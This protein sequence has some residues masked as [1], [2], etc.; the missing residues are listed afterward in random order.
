[1][2]VLNGVLLA[3]MLGP[4]E[5]GV[6][7]IAIAAATLLGTLAA[8][9]LP[10]L[11]TRDVA[12]HQ[13]Q[14]NWPLLKGLL[15]TSQLWVLLASLFF[16]L[17]GGALVFLDR[18]PATL[19]LVGQ[20][21]ILV[22]VPL[23]ALNLL[24]AGILR[25]L[26]SVLAA[27]VPDLLLRPLAVFVMLGGVY[28]SALE[29][30]AGSAL[31]I[32]TGAALLALGFGSWLLTRRLPEP[33]RQAMSETTHRQWL[34]S[35]GIFLAI[36]IVGML[37]GQVPL[38]LLGHLAG[39]EQAGLYQ[40]ANQIVGVVAMGLVAINM[41]LQPKLA[42]TWARGNAQHAQQLVTETARLGT[43]IALAA[44]M[45]VMV[46]A[47]AILRIYGVQY[48]EAAH[49]LRILAAGQLINAAAGS[50]GVLLMM[51]GYQR[52]VMQGT[53]VALLINASIAY[54]F[55]PEYGLLGGALAAMLAMIFWNVYFAVYAK[56]KLGVDT[57]IISSVRVKVF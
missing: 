6:Y 17:V 18:F 33:A 53:A 41:P 56:I 19:T 28:A 38:Y 35:S 1:M 40:A 42:A 24:R 23:I 57:T 46:F 44:M 36:T 22:L 32:Q 48:A 31:L 25:G 37:E 8:L 2:G 47:E 29:M 11:V 39:P 50:C 45:A 54:L 49:A 3:R 5:F 34:R 16:V 20:V 12:V 51:A 21:S 30:T 55:I 15:A 4:A 27:D 14:E 7:S 43:G 13:A 10:P 52:V 26:H 9:G